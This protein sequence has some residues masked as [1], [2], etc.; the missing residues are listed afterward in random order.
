MNEISKNGPELAGMRLRGHELLCWAIS[1]PSNSSFVFSLLSTSWG[2]L[3][4]DVWFRQPTSV[5]STTL[6]SWTKG[7]WQ[8]A[9]SRMSGPLYSF[10]SFFLLCRIN[11][12]TVIKIYVHK[13]MWLIRKPLF[14]YIDPCICYPRT[15]EVLKA[16]IFIFP[17]WKF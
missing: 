7:L 3:I 13:W 12:I 16:D 5:W 11:F 14:V 17:T 15:M 4:Y 8:I 2:P 9:Q 10:D 1:Q 6:R